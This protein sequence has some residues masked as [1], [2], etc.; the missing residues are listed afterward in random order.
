MGVDK[1]S[2]RLAGASLVEQTA[3]RLREVTAEVL[4]ADRGLGLAAGYRSIAD[5]PG[6]GPA[7][8]ILGAAAACP[9]RDLLV[10]AC[11][12][13]RVPAALLR[14]LAS[15]FGQDACVPRW[16][17]G[18]EP[19]CALYRPAALTAIADEVRAGRFALHSTLHRGDL[20]VEIL[21]GRTLEAFGPP[22]QVFLNL[23]TPEDLDLLTGRR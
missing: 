22:E 17:R 18:V 20:A 7:A 8:G 14:R 1:A 9:G 4:I 21:E 19:L 10:L 6:A 11:D 3:A 15:P 13:P 23:N 12:L 5:G 16:R 2:L